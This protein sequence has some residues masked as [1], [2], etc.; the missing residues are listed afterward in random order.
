MSEYQWHKGSIVFENDKSYKISLPDGNFIWMVKYLVPEHTA[1][2]ILIKESTYQ[3]ALD[4]LPTSD[5]ITAILQN[6]NAFLV[7]F[8][9]N[10]VRHLIVDAISQKGYVFVKLKS[11]YSVFIKVPLNDVQEWVKLLKKT[12]KNG[13]KY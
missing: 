3:R 2:S 12:A 9:P 4:E 7:N 10:F 6:K 11:K 1:D 5:E 13:S 8:A